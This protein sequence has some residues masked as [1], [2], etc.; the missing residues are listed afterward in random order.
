MDPMGISCKLCKVIWCAEGSSP[1]CHVTWRWVTVRWDLPR[2]HS[3]NWRPAWGSHEAK[4]G[5]FGSSWSWFIHVYPGIWWLFLAVKTPKKTPWHH[6]GNHGSVWACSVGLKI[7]KH[8]Q[9]YSH[10]G[11][12][13]I[14]HLTMRV[15]MVSPPLFCAAGIFWFVTGSPLDTTYT[16]NMHAYAKLKLPWIR[17]LPFVLSTSFTPCTRLQ[18]TLIPR[19]VCRTRRVSPV[20]SRNKICRGWLSSP[21]CPPWTQSSSPA[22]QRETHPAALPRHRPWGTTGAV[23]HSRRSRSN[24]RGPEVNHLNPSVN[25]LW[26]AIEVNKTSVLHVY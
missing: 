15:I 11:C 17:V 7:G 16:F 21:R 3:E 25:F 23:F 14:W 22:A 9:K 4:P 8:V 13:A 10:A 6:H 12:Q 5:L 2:I 19:T 24:L 1:F 20:W 26:L 18:A